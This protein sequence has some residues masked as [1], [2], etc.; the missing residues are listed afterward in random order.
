MISSG[1]AV[2]DQ[3]DDGFTAHDEHGS[4]V[5]SAAQAPADPRGVRMARW[6]QLAD[7]IATEWTRRA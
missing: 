1:G 2:T 5:V 4:T 7:E 3:V 6:S